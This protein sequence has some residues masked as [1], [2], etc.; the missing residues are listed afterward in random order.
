MNDTEIHAEVLQQSKPLLRGW[1]HLVGVF[2]LLGTSPLLIGRAQNWT[3]VIWVCCFIFGV[4]SMM[5][6][7]AL[8]GD[9]LITQLS[10]S[11]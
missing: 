7:S 2:V 11:Q 5:T 10:S 8:F 6:T 1:I 4:A 3:Q 9:V